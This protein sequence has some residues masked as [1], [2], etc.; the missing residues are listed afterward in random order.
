MHGRIIS[1]EISDERLRIFRRAEIPNA[2]KWDSWESHFN[3]LEVIPPKVDIGGAS[4]SNDSRVA[5][6][7]DLHPA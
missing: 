5:G 2:E 4:Q 7:P 1:S 3:S 6:E